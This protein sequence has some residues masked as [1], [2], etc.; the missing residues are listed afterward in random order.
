VAVERYP[1]AAIIDLDGLHTLIVNLQSRGFATRGPVVRDG[2]IVPDDIA[3]ARDLPIGYH[4]E[5]Q[6][7]R[8]R[9]VETG[10]N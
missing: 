1:D 9:L 10:D 3:G 4:D 5:Q 7:G 6:P 2:A 8:Y